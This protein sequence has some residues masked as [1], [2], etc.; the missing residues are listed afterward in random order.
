MQARQEILSGV[1][2]GSEYQ[3]LTLQS[4]VSAILA[5]SLTAEGKVSGGSK[6]TH[7]LFVGS[8]SSLQ[9]YNVHSNS[10]LFYKDVRLPRSMEKS[11]PTILSSVQQAT[12]LPVKRLHKIQNSL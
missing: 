9:A 7:T 3:L 5:G 11:L 2:T 4:Q 12:Q 1:D 6:A 8:P 10:E